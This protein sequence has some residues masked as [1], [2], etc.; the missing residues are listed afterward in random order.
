MKIELTEQE[1]KEFVLWRKHQDNFKVLLD[2]K[3]FETRNGRAIIHFDNQNLLRQIEIEHITW[4][5]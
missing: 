1:A 5:I 3:V 2:A 4:R